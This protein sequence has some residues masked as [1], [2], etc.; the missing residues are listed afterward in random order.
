M[1]DNADKKT[2]ELLPCRCSLR[3]S[4]DQTIDREHIRSCPAYFRPAVATVLREAVER[5]AH[6][7]KQATERLQAELEHAREESRLCNAEWKR[8]YEQAAERQRKAEWLL[9]YFTAS[10]ADVLYAKYADAILAQAEV[11]K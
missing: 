5:E 9:W 4:S 7:W 8:R 2:A 1:S 3:T 10:H 6:Q 11:K